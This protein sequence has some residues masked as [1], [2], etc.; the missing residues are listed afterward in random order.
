MW[1]FIEKRGENL[2]LWKSE[3]QFVPN[4]PGHIPT[5]TDTCCPV[6]HE[7][8]HRIQSASSHA[9]HRLAHLVR[10]NVRKR[11]KGADRRSDNER[12]RR[13]SFRPFFRQ[14][15]AGI[16]SAAR[17][18]G[19]YHG[20]LPPQAPGSLYKARCALPKR[21]PEANAGSPCPQGLGQLQVPPIG[22]RAVS[23]AV[24]REN[25]GHLMEAAPRRI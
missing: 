6:P 19:H 11:W 14:A 25:H 7:Q 4:P 16:V 13:I 3:S 5:R 21:T 2:N 15:P 10:H 9:R 24:P 20:A 8:N 12:T 17:H 1:R 23:G 18:D 22:L